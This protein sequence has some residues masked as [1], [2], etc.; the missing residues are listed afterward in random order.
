MDWLTTANRI[1]ELLETRGTIIDTRYKALLRFQGENGSD[2]I[3]D[4]ID[5]NQW[6]ASGDAALSTTIKKFGSSSLHL[7][8]TGDFIYCQEAALDLSSIG[9]F[10][11]RGFFYPSIVSGATKKT[12]FS[13]YLDSTHFIELYVQD[14]ELVLEIYNGGIEPIALKSFGSLTASAWHH[15]SLEYED[16]EISGYLDGSL[17][18]HTDPIDGLPTLSSPTTR[19]G[20]STGSAE[21]FSGYIGE[22]FLYHGNGY[23]PATTYTIPTSATDNLKTVLDAGATEI[24]ITDRETELD[25]PGDSYPLITI[26]RGRAFDRTHYTTDKNRFWQEYSIEV[27]IKSGSTISDHETQLGIARDIEKIIAHVIKDIAYA[28]SYWHNLLTVQPFTP[29]F[30]KD[31]TIILSEILIKAL[32]LES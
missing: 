6:L 29:K 14:S 11:L 27:A 3:I 17:A 8:G 21:F 2:E 24:R 23:Y 12:L 30:A 9:S 31:K 10:V 18:F 7:D 20:S 28:G 5:D 1:K 26:Y 4:D 25:P 15:F 16:S 22:I 32:L 19:I 13:Q